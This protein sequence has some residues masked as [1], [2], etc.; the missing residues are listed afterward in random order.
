MRRAANPNRIYNVRRTR[1]SPC[2]KCGQP[3]AWQQDGP[4]FRWV[5]VDVRSILAPHERPA[6]ARGK[7]PAGKWH[8]C[9]QGT[10]QVHDLYYGQI[11]P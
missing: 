7:T 5:P 11:T 3:I 1:V 6:W 8:Q 4:R 2:K 9:W 10:G